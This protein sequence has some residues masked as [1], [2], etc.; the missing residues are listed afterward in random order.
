[1]TGNQ[2]LE[3]YNAVVRIDPNEKDE[4]SRR[5]DV[6]LEPAASLAGQVHGPDGKPLPGAFVAGAHAVWSF[7]G[8]P[9]KLPSASFKV[10][11]S[12]P[13][14]ARLLVF[15]HPEKKLARV[16]KLAAGHTGPL[17]V[18]LEATGALAGRVLDARGRPWAGLTVKASYRVE[19]LEQVRRKGKGSMRLPI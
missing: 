10:H 6:A 3:Q 16:Q 4:K 1:K 14:D 5:R 8:G 18:R 2:I 13:Q 17:T 11:G 9:E 12:G 15:F 7:G 19:D